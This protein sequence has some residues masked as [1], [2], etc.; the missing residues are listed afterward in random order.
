MAGLPFILVPLRRPSSWPQHKTVGALLSARRLADF[1]AA[2][3]GQRQ[4]VR[5]RRSNKK[6]GTGLDELRFITPVPDDHDFVA[7]LRATLQFE[8]LGVEDDCRRIRGA[9]VLESAAG[10]GV[11]QYHLDH[12]RETHHR[13]VGQRALSVIAAVHGPREPQG[14]SAVKVRFV[15]QRARRVELVTIPAGHA[16]IFRCD[17]VH[18]GY[19]Y[20]RRN[21]RLFAYFFSD[22]H[23]VEAADDAGIQQTHRLEQRAVAAMLRSWHSAAA[24]KKRKEDQRICSG[25]GPV[26]GKRSRA[27]SPSPAGLAASCCQLRRG[28]RSG[29][30]TTSTSTSAATSAST[31]TSSLTATSS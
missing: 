19:A 9:H 23:A 20:E 16:L 1:V 5:L 21:L 2:H 6:K 10:C 14:N 12:R 28:R 17:A 29:R 18:S 25:A 30:R 8:G 15:N 7:V 27:R 31:A 3:C 4:S 26:T 22:A 24:P 11:Q 13:P